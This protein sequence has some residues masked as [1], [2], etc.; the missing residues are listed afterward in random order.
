[1]PFFWCWQ[2]LLRVFLVLLLPAPALPKTRPDFGGAVWAQQVELIDLGG[3]TG[4][5]FCGFLLHPPLN[6]GKPKRG[7]GF[8]A[9]ARVWGQRAGIGRGGRQLLGHGPCEVGCGRDFR[10]H[11]PAAKALTKLPS[12]KEKR[13]RAEWSGNGQRK[14]KWRKSDEQT[15]P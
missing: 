13:I 8:A 12:K 15:K 7:I 5:V 10:V 4:A 2:L 6:S 3:A 14:R 1:M 9:A 11:Q